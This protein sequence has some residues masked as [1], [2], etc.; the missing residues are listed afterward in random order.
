MS[1]SYD[2]T[3]PIFAS[4]KEIRKKVAGMKTD[5]KSK[6]EPKDPETCSVF[7]IYELFATESERAKLA[8]D[9]QNGGMGYGDAKAAL[10][11]KIVSHFASQ[12][13]LHR[14]LLDNQAGHLEAVLKEGAERARE[15]AQK[16]ISR[17]RKALGV[18]L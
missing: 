16:T 5:S 3:I 9:Y 13:T 15:R 12:R 11:D 10:A 6:D 8:F 18:G 17:L 7:K 14:D 1:K 2:N 4:E